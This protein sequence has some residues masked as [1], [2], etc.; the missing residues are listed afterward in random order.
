VVF[1]DAEVANNRF[2]EDFIGIYSYN[3]TGAIL[4][5]SMTS[6]W[7]GIIV[8]YA[9]PLISGNHIQGCLGN[10]TRFFVSN[11]TY[12]HNVLEYN[13]I[14]L[15]IPYD[16]RG[17]LANM[18]GNSVNGID[19]SNYYFQGVSGV[20][21]EGLYFDS[22]WS[23]GY[24]GYLN[25][26][27]AFTFYDCRDIVIENCV[28]ENNWHGLGLANSTVLVSNSTIG[29]MERSPG[30][31]EMGS[32]LT[33]N[34]VSTGG[35]NYS[36]RD[37]NSV[38]MENEYVRALVRNETLVPIEGAA[39]E[40]LENDVSIGTYHTD[41]TGHTP[42]VLAQDRFHTNISGTFVNEVGIDVTFEGR[43]FDDDPRTFELGTSRTITFTDLGDIWAPELAVERLGGEKSNLTPVFILTFSEEMDRASV[44]AATTMS[45]NVTLIFVWD[46]WNA[47]VTPSEPLEYETT[48]TLTITA[49]ATDLRGN[50]LDNPQDVHLVTEDAPPA[51]SD[52]TLMYVAIGAG[53]AVFI[54]ILA[55]ALVFRKTDGPRR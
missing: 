11:A 55:V 48:Y 29:A 41:A 26:Q 8:F 47:T 42:W 54:G 38:A 6:C 1:S 21:L 46:G 15:D 45:A 35:V 3:N 52:E 37:D 32:E 25:G 31:L 40:F 16:S 7:D 28:I 13:R 36:V 9:D 51:I 24:S 30:F 39:C 5:N 17:V 22:G 20:R 43:A 10:A 23:A 19:I 34:N 18:S 2:D 12:T 50:P 4:G 53:V 33:A 14:G 44:E 27:G 49:G